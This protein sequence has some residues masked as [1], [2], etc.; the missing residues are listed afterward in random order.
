VNFF[1]HAAVARW[2]SESPTV[3]LGAMLPDF[4][5]MIRAR[6]PVVRE[7]LLQRGV[8]LHHATDHAFHETSVFRELTAWAH[9]DLAERGL[10][11][12]PARAVAHVGVEILIDG[13]LA[14]DDAARRSYLAALTLGRT[15][16][17][18]SV[19]WRD[20]ASSLAFAELVAALC[21]RGIS[22]S[23]HTPE[24][25]ALRVA[26]ALAP[27]PRLAL[28]ANDEPRVIA[29]AHAAR[30]RVAARGDALV[31]ELRRMLESASGA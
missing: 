23:H 2:Y 15:L 20:G 7:P 5:A 25:L 18:A 4:A 11:R 14:H 29:W 10:A 8:A 9:A 17:A 31:K 26:R 12:G 16:D 30:P 13:V 3:A 1:G 6:P 28:G 21:A 27:R 24:V 19:S 22:R